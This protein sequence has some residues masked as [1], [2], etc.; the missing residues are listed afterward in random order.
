MQL[1]HPVIIAGGGPVGLVTALTPAQRGLEVKLFEAEARVDDSPRAAATHAATL[2]M[3]EKLGIVGEVTRRGLIE[4]KFRIW[5]RVSREI[6]AAFDFGLLRDDTRSPHVVQCE[7][8]KLANIVL[9]RLGALPNVT[10]AFSARV[11]AVE[12]RDGHVEVQVETAKGSRRFAESYLIGA[13]G[14]RS[15]VRRALEID[16]EGYTHPERFLVLTTTHAFGDE[17]AACSR[18][19]FSD[20]NEVAGDDGKGRWRVVFPIGPNE[21]M[22]SA[23]DEAAVQE[24]LQRFFPKMAS[25]PVVHRNLYNVHQHVAASFRKRRVFLAGDGA[26]INNPVAGLGLNFGIHDGIELSSL[27]AGVIR[28]SAGAER[29][30]RRHAQR[31]R[32]TDAGAWPGDDVGTEASL[33]RRT[34][35]RPRAVG[36]VRH[37]QD[38]PH[39]Q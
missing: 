31:W 2:E 7:Q 15:T 1:E 33:P 26:H 30:E 14:G 3:L 13:D 9:A 18:N 35:A 4:P 17:F 37:L 11:G 32:A 27:L 22:E 34:F 16:F 20:P 23:F 10:I 19:Y 12:Q 29:P 21:T 28:K 36:R 39:H 5:D 8:H 38:H 6:I 24:R 25:Y